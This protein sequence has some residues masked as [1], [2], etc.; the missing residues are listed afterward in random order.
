MPSVVGRVCGD[1]RWVASPIGLTYY[2]RL[3]LD[4]RPF[5][6]LHRDLRPVGR[7]GLDCG[8]F[9]TALFSAIY[10]YPLRKKT[11]YR[12]LRVREKSRPQAAGAGETACPGIDCKQLA[13]VAQ[14][15]SPADFE[16]E[17]VPRR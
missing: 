11:G 4:D 16:S 13:L 2:Y 8:I 9:S 6:P 10:L 7:I 15:V 5:H 12:T 3:P 14:A 17:P 1:Y